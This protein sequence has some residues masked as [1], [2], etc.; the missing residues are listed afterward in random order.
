MQLDDVIQMS[1]GELQSKTEIA[2]AVKDFLESENRILILSGMF[3]QCMR[4]VV[5]RVNNILTTQ[6]CAEATT[7]IVPAARMSKGYGPSAVSVYGLVYEKRAYFHKKEQQFIHDKRTCNKDSPDHV[8]IAGEAHLISDSLR[9]SNSR[10]FG[11][12]HLLADLMEF[13]SL[14]GAQ[15]QIIFIG[16]PYQLSIGSNTSALSITRLRE[17]SKFVKHVHISDFKCTRG[18]ELFL[19]N[20]ELIAD[21]IRTHQFGRLNIRLGEY[22]CTQLSDT[23][24]E[25][26]RLIKDD[27]A[28][29]VAYTNA[30]VHQYNQAIRNQVFGQESRLSRGDL[31]ILHNHIEICCD[32]CLRSC[33]I[34]SGSFGTVMEILNSKSV[35]Q[36][37]LGRKKKVTVNF[38]NIRIR[39][40]NS[41]CHH[42]QIL[43]CFEDFL[44]REKPELNKDEWLALVVHA[45]SLKK[46]K[47]ESK[48]QKK[49]GKLAQNAPN[50]TE[51]S[52]EQSE[53]EQ[54]HKG[55]EKEDLD[56]PYLRAA[57][58]R[59][60][61]AIT[62][63]RA[64]GCLFRTVIADLSERTSMGGKAYFRWLY[65]AFSVS[66]QSLHLISVPRKNPLDE[67]IWELDKSRLSYSIQPANLIGYNPSAPNPAQIT[68]SPTDHIELRNLYKFIRGRLTRM[69]VQV[70]ELVHHQ[71]QEVYTFEAGSESRCTLQLYYNRKFDITRILVK[72]SQPPELAKRILDSLSTHPVFQNTFQQEIHDILC[73]RLNSHDLVITAVEHHD[74]QE[75]YFVEGSGGKAKFRAH[76]N[77]KAAVT[78]I[79]LTEHSSEQFRNHL[80][81]TIQA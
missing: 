11:S 53:N 1:D 59:F 63:H 64:Q 7:V 25:I 30:Q 15:R 43:L 10:R 47:E 66:D 21:R 19:E 9:E 22:E 24:S 81:S 27:L 54:K 72:K 3:A 12:G 44:Y 46:S 49:N 69:N 67:T 61:Y 34:A 8:Y 2:D 6:I 55:A 31:V 4:N 33:K 77:K 5:D 45:R 50:Q 65:T 74:F 23:S 16:D 48:G 35:E 42:D 80:K 37:L 62:L 20:R 26:D 32:Q 58:L 41:G 14:S 13:I 39:W 71:F 68:Q 17:Y 73:K 75:T 52:L 28:T 56:S 36:G 70:S 78:K 29:T 40:N 79:I 51:E 18:S 76:Y 60:G 38:L 57:M